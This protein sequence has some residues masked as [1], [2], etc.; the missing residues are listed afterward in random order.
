MS[1]WMSLSI[2]NV[3]VVGVGALASCA[4]SYKGV[5][6]PGVKMNALSPELESLTDQ[7]IETYLKADV[8]PSFPTVLA[9]AKLA[10]PPAHA[11]YSRN[12]EPAAALAVPAGDE[13]AGWRKLT[14]ATSNSET[15]PVEQVQFVTALLAPGKP[16]LKSLR[17]AAAMLHAPLLLVYMQDDDAQEGYNDLAMAYWTFV[18]LFCVPG[19][20][21]GHYT[22]CQ[23]VLVD[24]RS[25]FILATA[26]GEAK[27]EENVLPGAV[28]IAWDRVA[29][30]AQAEAVAQLQANT[31][32]TLRA[33]ASSRA[34]P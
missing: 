20:A 15:P 31:L 22:V 16:T 1:R 30:Q 5:V 14:A 32:E 34:A 11:C 24:T 27:R 9:V 6:K 28:S 7:A 17:D 13:A 26:Q 25:G 10:G 2:V 19:N 18:G 3:V 23:A 33:L 29:R 12:E 8:R 4:P 21:V